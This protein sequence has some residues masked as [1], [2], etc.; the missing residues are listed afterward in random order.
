[1]T[2]YLAY[3]NNGNKFQD[4]TINDV[5]KNKS[6]TFIYFTEDK[7]LAEKFIKNTVNKIT[8]GISSIVINKDIAFSIAKEQDFTKITPEYFQGTK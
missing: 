2:I 5:V 7:S 3:Y 4:T 1:M 8:H 6:G